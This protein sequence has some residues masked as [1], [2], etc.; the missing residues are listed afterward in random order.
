MTLCKKC[1]RSDYYC[2]CKKVSRVERTNINS[3]VSEAV[4]TITED[5]PTFGF[6]V[7]GKCDG[8]VFYAYLRGTGGPKWRIHEDNFTDAQ[9]SAIRRACNKLNEEA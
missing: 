1:G 9:K 5:G 8:L 3:R 2:E 4:L 7:V 6:E